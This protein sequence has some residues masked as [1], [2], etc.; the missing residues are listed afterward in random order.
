MKNDKFDDD[1]VVRQVAEQGDSKEGKDCMA[2]H[3]VVLDN[4]TTVD[5]RQKVKVRLM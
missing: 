2:K 3:L 5:L 1:L 4:K